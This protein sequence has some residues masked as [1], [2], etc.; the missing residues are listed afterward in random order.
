MEAEALEE[1]CWLPCFSGSYS[2]TFLND[3]GPPAQ[4]WYHLQ[5]AELPPSVINQNN[6]LLTFLQMNLMKTFSQLDLSSQ[7]T[8]GLCQVDENNKL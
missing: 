6:A 2:A 8:L 7:M 5:W 3:A 1:Y 4:D